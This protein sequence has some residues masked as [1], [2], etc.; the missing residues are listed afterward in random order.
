LFLN[1]GIAVIRY[2]EDQ[3]RMFRFEDCRHARISFIS[4]SFDYKASTD[5]A[6]EG[7]SKATKISERCALS[8]GNQELETR[9]STATKSPQSALLPYLKHTSKGSYRC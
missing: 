8:R 7:A 1:S 9:L 3:A 5:S 6:K 2:K 4:G